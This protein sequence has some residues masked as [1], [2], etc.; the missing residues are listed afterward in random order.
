[1]VVLANEELVVVEVVLEVGDGIVQYRPVLAVE[2]GVVP[3]LRLQQVAVQL[4]VE[5]G[6]VR[7]LAV[8][9]GQVR[10]R[11]GFISFH[12]SSSSR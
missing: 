11:A 8:E 3:P 1:M 5:L 6:L 9:E 4:E 12:V 10:G 2:T 7:V